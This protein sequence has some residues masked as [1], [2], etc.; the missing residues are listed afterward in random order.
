[1]LSLHY[2]Y[3]LPVYICRLYILITNNSVR[4]AYLYRCTSLYV[5]YRTGSNRRRWSGISWC[6]WLSYRLLMSCNWSLVCLNEFCR[7]SISV[8][9]MIVIMDALWVRYN[10]RWRS[11]VCIM[12]GCSMIS[13]IILN[14]STCNEPFII[15]YCI[16]IKT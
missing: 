11:L 10:C 12:G 2:I 5:K 8:W 15:L 13:T 16:I 4:I 7:F 1:M 6:E 3:I 14:S 9:I